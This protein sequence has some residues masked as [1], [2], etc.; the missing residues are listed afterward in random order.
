LK[1]SDFSCPEC[2]HHPLKVNQETL[3]C[4]GCSSVFAIHQTVPL[5]FSKAELSAVI[6]GHKTSLE[7]A[8]SVYDQVYKYD[9]LMGTDFDQN[10]DMETKTRLLGFAGNLDEKRLLDLGTGEG[11][12]WDYAPKNVIGYALDISETG[13]I[14][15]LKRR[16]DLTV[17]AAAGEHL[18][19]LDTFFDAIISADTIEHTFSPE[20]TLAEVHRALKMGG[21]FAAS[22]PTPDSLQKWGR[23]LVTAR[24]LRPAFLF[25]LGTVLLKRIWL[26]G[27]ATFQPIDRDLKMQEWTSLLEKSGFTIV[28]VLEW[29]P[30]PFVPIVYLVHC[31]KI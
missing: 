23:N 31:V 5:L 30:K 6:E 12:L 17:S 25:H 18:P 28:E 1:Y 27:K 2:H 21:T 24:K 26:F 9:G 29:P 11:N 13:A 8:K 19:Y 15:A 4:P 14:K 22:F 10:Y 20:K 7:E 3:E 16:P